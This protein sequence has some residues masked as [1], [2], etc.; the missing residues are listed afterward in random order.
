[1]TAQL[2]KHLSLASFK[3]RRRRLHHIFPF[4]LRLFIL[5]AL[6]ILFFLLSLP[7]S[8]KSFTQVLVSSL[9]SHSLFSFSCDVLD[10]LRLSLPKK[11]ETKKRRPG[12]ERRM[13]M[14]AVA[15]RVPLFSVRKKERRR[16][17][18]KLGK[19]RGGSRAKFTSYVQSNL[20]ISNFSVSGKMLLILRFC[21]YRD[22]RKL[23]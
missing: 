18:K 11:A 3:L 9:L 14:A 8:N 23:T 2:P 20:D 6:A 15:A 22:S 7:A 21:L 1:M 12:E 5:R 10:E 4:F 16:R 13:Q 19:K 17:R